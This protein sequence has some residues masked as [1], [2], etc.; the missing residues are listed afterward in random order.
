MLSQGLIVALLLGT[1]GVPP[2]PAVG[3]IGAGWVLVSALDA[4]AEPAHTHAEPGLSVW[5]Q[6]QAHGTSLEAEL[7]AT[8]VAGAPGAP[9]RA[10]IHATGARSHTYQYMPRTTAGWVEASARLAA[11]LTAAVT[12]GT[13]SAALATALLYDDSLGADAVL[14]TAVAVTAG[15]APLPFTPSGSPSGVLAVPRRGA[16][17]DWFSFHC[18]THGRTAVHIEQQPAAA[19]TADGNAR[20]T[21]E[22][23]LRLSA[24][25]T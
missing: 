6:V 1:A 4:R 9:V 24:V 8:A 19:T 17:T 3:G 13:A 12:G 25:G 21:I 22:I 15:G 23:E 2:R 14:P 18:E 16:K 5:M 10:A 11:R 7:A 20:A